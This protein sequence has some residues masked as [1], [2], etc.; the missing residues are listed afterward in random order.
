MNQ[1]IPKPIF[2]RALRLLKAINLL[3]RRGFEDLACTFLAGTETDSWMLAICHIDNLLVDGVD[4]TA[5]IIDEKAEVYLHQHTNEGNEYFGWH[6]LKNAS[7]YDLSNAIEERC[8]PLMNKSRLENRDN[9]G[10]FTQVLG[11]AE[12]HQSLPYASV[13]K[14]YEVPPWV[15]VLGTPHFVSLPPA[16]KVLTVN[17]EKYYFKRVDVFQCNDWHSSHI[18]IINNVTSGGI[19]AL[20]KFPKNW[21]DI[22]EMGA[23]W[24]GAVYFIFKHLRINSTQEFLLF[25]EGQRNYYPMADWFYRIYNSEG[26][27]DHFIAFVVRKHIRNQNNILSQSQTVWKHWLKVFEDRT[28]PRYTPCDSYLLPTSCDPY[29]GGDNPLDLGFVFTYEDANWLNN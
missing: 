28:N 4:R 18:Q 17:N 7:A 20:P 3:H 22:T 2:R 6:D 23:Y 8:T 5:T 15:F 26:Q 21:T 25:L 27:L 9:I 12:L 14:H 29:Y 24:E 13:N 16:C 11:F 19:V 1:L 10:W